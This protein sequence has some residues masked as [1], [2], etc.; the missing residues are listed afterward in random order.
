MNEASAKYSD[1]LDRQAFIT[2]SIRTFT[3]GG[4]AEREYLGRI[5]QGFFGFHALGAFG[6]AALERL[7]HAKSTVW[8]VDSNVQISLL[9]LGATVSGAWRGCLEGLRK[10]GV[11]LFTTERL[12]DE[13]REHW[14]FADKVVKDHGPISSAVVAAARG[15]PPFRRS[16][17]FLEG[18]VEWQAAGNPPG[19]EGY[20]FRAFGSRRPTVDNIARS[21][22]DLGIEIVAFQDWP[23][24]QD[25]DF[26][27][28]EG[29]TQSIAQLRQRRDRAIDAFQDDWLRD[30]FPKAKP[31]AEALL[32]TTKERSGAYFML[33]SPGTSS[34][35]WFVSDTSV[36]N[37]V[38]RTSLRITWQPEAFLRFASTLSAG[39]DSAAASR[40]F[41]SLLW[42][43]AQS[44]LS[45]L[46]EKD[47]EKVFGGII[48]Q[49]II[50]IKEMRD[51]VRKDAGGQIR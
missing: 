42:G 22:T 24:F 37:L 15:D 20:N 30:V 44:G 21:L 40:A 10:L 11:R 33:S 38:E 48:D 6:E 16:N 29:Y 17:M 34:P 45:L 39:G 14:W 28:R 2:T 26:E 50:D 36:L 31:E 7:K 13:T 18:F 41:D 5:A 8:M 12:F 9:A 43:L 32:I 25:S 19:W 47:A 51:M 1:L 3:N 4:S 49:A 23:G 35:A 46:D 27:L